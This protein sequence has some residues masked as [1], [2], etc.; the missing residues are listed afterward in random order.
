M[1][2]IGSDEIEC[3]I[4]GDARLAL[5]SGSRGRSREGI[6]LPL[7]FEIGFHLD[8]ELTD[9]KWGTSIIDRASADLRRAFPEMDGLRIL[10]AHE[11]LCQTRHPLSF[12]ETPA[13]VSG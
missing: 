8:R 3:V 1:L 4:A 10:V 11:A 2:E 5:A 9:E 13:R 7:Y 12:N 6:A